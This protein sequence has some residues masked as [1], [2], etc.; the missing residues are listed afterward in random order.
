MNLPLLLATNNPGKLRELQAL[1]EGLPLRV[2]L[3]AAIGLKV[4][5]AEEGQSYAENAQHKALT[6][7]RVSGLLSLADDSG[8]EVDALN[9]APGLHSAR[10]HPQPNASDGQRRA[11]LLEHLRPFPRPWRARFHAVLVLATPEGQT[12]QGEGFCEG[13]IIPEERGTNGF[14][15]DPIFLVHEYGRTMA[16]LSLEEK[17]RVSHRARAFQ[18]L[19]PILLQMLEQH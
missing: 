16:E 17:N 1:L 19:R 9:G 13:E 5:P 10:Y 15:Y 4:S 2:L 7:A 12:W 18:A 6:F 3:P 14:G 8:L 11:L